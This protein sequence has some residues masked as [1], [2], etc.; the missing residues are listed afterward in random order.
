VALDRGRLDDPEAREVAQYRG[1]LVELGVEGRGEPFELVLERLA[2]QDVLALGQV[3]H[4]VEVLEAFELAGQLAAAAGVGGGVAVGLVADGVQGEGAQ[5]LV[6]VEAPDPVDEL[7]LKRLG[8][9]HRLRAVTAVATGRALVAAH[10]G[11]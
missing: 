11:A 10:A 9:D 5:I 4:D 6:E 7:G 1:G 3:A 8:L 2:T